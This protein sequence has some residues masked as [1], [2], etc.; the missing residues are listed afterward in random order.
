MQGCS[1]REK[2]YWISYQN[3]NTTSLFINLS[4]K[5]HEFP[6]RCISRQT[7]YIALAMEFTKSQILREATRIPNIFRPRVRQQYEINLKPRHMR[8]ELSHRFLLVLYWMR[9]SEMWNLGEKNDPTNH[10]V[11]IIKIRQR[12][13]II[14]IQFP[15]ETWSK[16][17]R[18]QL[19]ILRK[20]TWDPPTSR[21]QRGRP[22]K[23]S[24][25]DHALQTSN[26]TAPASQRSGFESCSGLPRCY[27][28][29][30][31]KKLPGSHTSN[32]VSTPSSNTW[33]SC[34]N[35]IYIDLGNILCL[36][37][38]RAHATTN[39]PLPDLRSSP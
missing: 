9:K 36:R 16:K 38:T 20:A 6:L 39:T 31:E 23:F 30:V 13:T 37:K 2:L 34:M 29:S 18:Q 35:I 17:K 4:A 21:K 5:I 28:S 7:G 22:E 32:F 25:K 10:I 8:D 12:Q 27:I 19:D 33:L 11:K 1:Q 24:F 3:W 14:S 15:T 26:S